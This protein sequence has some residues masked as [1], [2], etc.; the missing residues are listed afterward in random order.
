MKNKNKVNRLR[1]EQK[2]I[3]H[4]HLCN[5]VK[6]NS[7]HLAFVPY[8]SYSMFVQSVCNMS[9]IETNNKPLVYLNCAP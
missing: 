8:A 3:K 7:Q 1:K 5:E 9:T 2:V 6:N 4:R